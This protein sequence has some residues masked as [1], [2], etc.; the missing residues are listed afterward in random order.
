MNLK[1]DSVFIGNQYEEKIQQDILVSH[2]A[3]EA[4]SDQTMVDPGE[5]TVDGSDSFGLR[6][7]IFFHKLCLRDI[8]IYSRPHRPAHT[9]NLKQKKENITNRD[10]CFK[11]GYFSF[12]SIFHTRTSKPAFRRKKK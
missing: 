6:D 1:T 10:R 7:V 11:G 9:M 4:V 3:E 5:R 8:F 12:L 2:H